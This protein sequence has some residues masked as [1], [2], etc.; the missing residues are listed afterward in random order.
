ME[1]LRQMAAR[2]REQREISGITQEKMAETLGVDLVLY[3]QYEIDGENVPINI[4]FRMAHVFGVDMNEI[5]T[6]RTPHL[7]SYCLVKKGKGLSVDRY[8]G[9]SFQSLAYTYKR[10][11]M[12]PLLVTVQPSE[13][14]AAL[15]THGGQEFNMCLEGVMEVLIENKVIRLEAGDSI[16]FN[17]AKPHG[18]RAVGGTAKFLTVIAE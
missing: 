11:M 16:Y 8:P 4:L 1:E 13:K 17:P 14:D 3:K 2:I 18:Q 6:G 7:E 5:L 12:E 9:Y 10:R 15:V